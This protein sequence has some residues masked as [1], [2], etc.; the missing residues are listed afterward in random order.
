MCWFPVAVEATENSGKGLRS[1]KKKKAKKNKINALM[2][3]LQYLQENSS[4]AEAFNEK[5]YISSGKK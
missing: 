2:R 4:K 1:L 5:E 3:Q